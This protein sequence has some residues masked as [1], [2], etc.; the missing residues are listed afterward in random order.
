[1]LSFVHNNNFASKKLDH[2]TA[3]LFRRF[4]FTFLYIGPNNYIHIETVFLYY[5]LFLLSYEDG[6][7]YLISM[8]V[9]SNVLMAYVSFYY[10]GNQAKPRRFCYLSC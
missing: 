8:P 5:I 4:R 10:L 6:L 3:N 9:L 7:L 1:M 2:K